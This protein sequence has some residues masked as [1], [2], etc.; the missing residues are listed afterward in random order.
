MIVSPASQHLSACVNTT[1]THI[2]AH[3]QTGSNRT[4]RFQLSSPVHTVT[5]EV[6]DASSFAAFIFNDSINTVTGT[7]KYFIMALRKV[8][9]PCSLE[10]G[11]TD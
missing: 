8:I 6:R 7:D 4:P 1:H 11:R 9:V 3:S 10:E 2:Y 5:C